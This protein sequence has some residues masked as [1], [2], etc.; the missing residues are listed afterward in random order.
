MAKKQFSRKRSG[1]AEN[2]QPTMSS[3]CGRGKENTQVFI[4]RGITSKTG[5]ATFAFLSAG[6]HRILFGILLFKKD[7]VQLMSTQRMTRDRAGAGGQGWT[8]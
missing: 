2:H 3:C 1:V 8:R 7:K 4:A 5:E 6:K